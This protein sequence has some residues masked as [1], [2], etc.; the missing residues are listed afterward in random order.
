VADSVEDLEADLVA[1]SVAADTGAFRSFGSQTKDTRPL[2]T[3]QI[4]LLSMGQLG[5]LMFHRNRYRHQVFRSIL[6]S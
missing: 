5:T 1:D 4:A 3:L 2:H 6:G